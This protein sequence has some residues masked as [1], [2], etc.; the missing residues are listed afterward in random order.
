M[1]SKQSKLGL[2]Y[3]RSTESEVSSVI[4]FN[5]FIN[6][7]S[8]SSSITLLLQR[9]KTVNILKINVVIKS[10]QK[11]SLILFNYLSYQSEPESSL[12]LAD[13]TL[14][15]LFVKNRILH[16]LATQLEYPRLR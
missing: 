11:L 8:P 6:G 10:Y 13:V 15:S 16:D 4:N 2:S 3:Y 1:E 5:M 7:A 14:L 12:R 9:K